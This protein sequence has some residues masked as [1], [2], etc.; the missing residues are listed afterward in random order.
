[1]THDEVP[2]IP[3]E[4]DLPP[5]SAEELVDIAEQAA[6]DDGPDAAE[7]VD[8]IAEPSTVIER[9][10]RSLQVPTESDTDV[11]Q[12]GLTP[13]A[14]AELP[15]ATPTESPRPARAPTLATGR[16]I[17]FGPRKLPPPSDFEQLLEEFS[18]PLG[19]HSQPQ[20]QEQWIPPAVTRPEGSPAPLPLAPP[21]KQSEGTVSLVV[22]VTLTQETQD[23]IAERAIQRASR[24]HQRHIEIVARQLSQLETEVRQRE[25]ERRV[26]SRHWSN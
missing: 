16:Q 10:S 12:E 7:P 15:D 8:S 4:L 19:S 11:A 6:A 24:V 9:V 20:V 13:P 1:L 2:E 26:L 25:A 5:E 3:S 23:R 21:G 22:H 18:R 14:I 17:V